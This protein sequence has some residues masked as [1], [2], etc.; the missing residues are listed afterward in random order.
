VNGF[1]YYAIIR[2]F[3][4]IDYSECMSMSMEQMQAMVTLHA[5]AIMLGERRKLIEKAVG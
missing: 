3:Y 1:H 4:N 5:M 2:I